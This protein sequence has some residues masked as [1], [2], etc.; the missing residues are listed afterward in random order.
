MANNCKMYNGRTKY[1]KAPMFIFEHDG[2]LYPFE[3]DDE[4]RHMCM[5]NRSFATKLWPTIEDDGHGVPDAVLRPIME[6]FV[7]VWEG[8]I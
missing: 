5:D 6:G 2:L 1:T 4:T 8:K 7:V 3:D